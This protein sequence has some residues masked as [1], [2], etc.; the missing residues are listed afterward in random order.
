MRKI[1]WRRERLP[2]PVSGLENSMDSIV[3]E[4][5]KSW[6]RLRDF[7]SRQLMVFVREGHRPVQ[8][9]VN[10]GFRLKNSLDSLIAQ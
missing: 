9:P 3:H 10:K 6:T 1:P 4:V 5:A 8:R 7:H 2:T